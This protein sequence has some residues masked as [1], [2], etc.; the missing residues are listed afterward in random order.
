MITTCSEKSL[1]INDVATSDRWGLQR[2]TGSDHEL[3]MSE[4][5]GGVDVVSGALASSAGQHDVHKR[6]TAFATDINRRPS[7]QRPS[8]VSWNALDAGFTST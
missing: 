1:L 4:R 7:I 5:A 2:N 8:T 3:A 6:S